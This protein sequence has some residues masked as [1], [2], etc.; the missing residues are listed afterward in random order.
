MI[1]ERL[2]QAIIDKTVECSIEFDVAAAACGFDPDELLEC[3]DAKPDS[4]PLNIY[5]HLGRTQIEKTAQFL[6]C[7]SIRIFFLADVLRTKDVL[8]LADAMINPAKVSSPDAMRHLVERL[9]KESAPAEEIQ[10]LAD[11]ALEGSAEAKQQVLQ[12]LAMF[13]GDMTKSKFVGHPE[14]VLDELIAA[15]FSQ[16]LDEACR[17][18]GLP[19]QTLSKWQQRE[20]ATL[21]DLDSM[22]T[23]AQIVGLPLSP[24]LLSLKVALPS[25]LLWDGLPVNLV[26]EFDKALDV[27]IW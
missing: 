24:V 12:A 13:Y 2:Y 17:K 20:P 27:E 8:A 11:S 9:G 21:R 1:A 26:D 14:V 18:T 19:L 4:R 23:L 5:D 25:D 16:S 10:A 22:R 3:F 7:P 6:G 15:T